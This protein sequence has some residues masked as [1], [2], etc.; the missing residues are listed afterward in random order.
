MKNRSISQ[1]GQTPRLAAYLMALPLSMCLAGP[2]AVH[3]QTLTT[4]QSFNGT[5][6][7]YPN[8]KLTPAPPRHRVCQH[9]NGNF[10][11]TTPYGG[12]N[13]DGTVYELTPQSAGGVLTTIHSFSGPDGEVPDGAL[14]LGS[15]GNLYGTTFLGGA[16]NDGTVFKITTSGELTTLYSFGSKANNADG[17]N[18][19][20]ALV[21]GTDGNFYGTTYTGGNSTSSG[22]VFKITPGG[23]LTTIHSFS[24]PDGAG[25]EGDLVQSA[26]NGNF[27]GL[28]F[29]GGN[30][31]GGNSGGNG[32]A[33]EISS[34]GAL[35][36]IYDFCSKTNC[37]DG[38]YPQAP[39][40]PDSY[41][42]FYGTTE[43]S[44]ANDWGTLFQINSYG[45]LHTLYHFCSKST[46]S[47]SCTDGAEPAGGPLVGNDGNLYGTTALGGADGGGTI[48]QFTPW[49]VLN[50][51]YNF[52][53]KGGSSCTDGETPEAPLVQG[54][55]Q[56]YY[57]TTAFG[58]T[59]GDGTSFVLSTIPPSG[60]QCNGIYSGSYWGNI[61]VSNG[62]SCEW[63]DGGQIYGNVY[64][65]GGSLNLNNASV[66][67][68]VQVSGG[69]YTLGPALSIW[70]TLSIQN[71]PSGSAENTICGVNVGGSLYF[72]GN[73]TAAQ[74]GSSSGSCPG[75]TIGGDL[76]VD[77]N[78]ALVQV[79]NNSAN[80]DLTGNG[81]SSI[82]GG[83]NTAKNKIG[84]CSTF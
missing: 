7:A 32:T 3:A 36:T 68:N 67:G 69:T 27:Y 53:S 55:D 51:L 30:T 24:G 15:D 8:T 82:T 25:P 52:C 62:Q 2:P 76:E 17:A 45:T 12:A 47:E 14:A 57:G 80:D 61:V 74:I 50:T 49:G 40:T 42:N 77:N 26:A 1:L 41:G 11:G 10:Y 54:T 9:T 31:N 79:F 16:N 22:T 4:L 65:T 64:V 46:S 48:Y 60:N 20:G 34:S 38:T 72:D 81:N 66:F 63:T 29:A 21:Q 5:N 84:Q 78:S 23:S 56:N 58:G 75:N 18:P 6:G 73:G 71:I 35:T 33:Y 44:G 19:F 13:G 43:L 39:L 37:N 28:T 70:S 59:Y 83:G